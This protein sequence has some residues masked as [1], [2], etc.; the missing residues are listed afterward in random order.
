MYSAYEQA[1]KRQQEMQEVAV[2]QRYGLMFRRV[3]RAARRVERAERNLAQTR[4]HREAVTLNAQLAGLE[5]MQS[6]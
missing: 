4:C 6:Q 5:L 3:G 2:E 1:I